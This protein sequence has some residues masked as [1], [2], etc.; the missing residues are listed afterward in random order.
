M[1]AARKAPRPGGQHA[2]G[3]TTA[4]DSRSGQLEAWPGCAARPRVAKAHATGR[5]GTVT[6]LNPQPPIAR[7]RDLL[8]VYDMI[9]IRT[10]SRVTSSG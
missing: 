8:C 1:L 4:A 3:A 9:S 6:L 10:G 7:L 2:G 5:D